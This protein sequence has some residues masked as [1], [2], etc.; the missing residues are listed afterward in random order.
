VRSLAACVA[1]ARLQLD[2]VVTVIDALRAPSVL[3]FDVAA[4]QLGFA[5]VVVLSHVDEVRAS[6]ALADTVQ[7]VQRH[8][9]VA[10][11]VQA[12]RGRVLERRVG[13]ALVRNYREPRSRLCA[14]SASFA[15]GC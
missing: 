1:T 4:E 12:H 7:L 6:G 14:F 10:V 2:G 13:S 3:A 15:R 9:P 8:A 5:D 11:V